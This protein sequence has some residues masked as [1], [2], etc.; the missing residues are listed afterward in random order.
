MEACRADFPSLERRRRRSFPLPGQRLHDAGAATGHRVD[1][2]VLY[3][4]SRLRREKEPSLVCRR[5]DPARRGDA[6]QGIKGARQLIAEFINAR[7]EKEILFTLNTTHAI[8]TVALASRFSRAMWFCSP[9]GNTT[10]ICFP[11]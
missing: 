6:G 3:G 9:T 5:G 8:N 1:Q 2:R 10:R 4:F 11:G 7:S